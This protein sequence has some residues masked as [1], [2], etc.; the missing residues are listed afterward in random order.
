[1]TGKI[2]KR[3]IDRRTTDDLSLPRILH[4][5]TL[6]FLFTIIVQ[7]ERAGLTAVASSVVFII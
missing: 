4:T 2:V 6:V 7:I 1:M 3:Q 5:F